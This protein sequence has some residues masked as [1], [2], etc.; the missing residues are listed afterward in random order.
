SN[1]LTDYSCGPCKLVELALPAAGPV[2]VRVDWSGSGP[3]WVGL[4]GDDYG[5]FLGLAQGMT[6]KVESAVTIS[7][8]VD[9]RKFDPRWLK[10]GLPYGARARGGLSGVSAVG[11]T[12]RSIAES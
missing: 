7:I 5:P 1:G 3:L 8:P 6:T 2:E 9:M 11:I 12:V 4:E 10:I